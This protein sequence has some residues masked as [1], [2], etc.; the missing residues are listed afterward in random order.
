MEVFISRDGR[1]EGSVHFKRL[2]PSPPL[3]C[4]C[5]TDL[6]TLEEIEELVRQLLIVPFYY[7]G[8]VGSFRWRLSRACV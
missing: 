5:P 8:S 1:E 6:L 2:Q 7:A 3:C 4:C